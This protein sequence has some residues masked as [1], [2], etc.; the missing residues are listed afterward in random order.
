MMTKPMKTLE[1]HYP[2]I[3]FLT[4]HHISLLVNIVDVRFGR[5]DAEDHLFVRI[6]DDWDGDKKSGLIY[7]HVSLCIPSYLCMDLGTL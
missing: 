3:E 5:K 1:W 4:T 7:G 2:M 6:G